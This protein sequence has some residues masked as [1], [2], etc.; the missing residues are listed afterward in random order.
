MGF[1][2]A[3]RTRP[4]TAGEFTGI[5]RLL[6]LAAMLGQRHIGAARQAGEQAEG[7]VRA[8]DH[9]LEQEVH[10]VRHALP[11]MFWARG[12]GWPAAFHQLAVGLAEALRRRHDTFVE[13]HAL[14]IG[15]AMDRVQNF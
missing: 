9:F 15:A 2:Q 4:F 1:G 3:H 11:A 8:V 5:E 12:E 6:F 14:L 13:M 7:Q 10:H